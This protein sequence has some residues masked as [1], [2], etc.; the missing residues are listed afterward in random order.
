MLSFNSENTINLAL[1]A[2]QSIPSPNA[3]DAECL[4]LLKLPTK[5]QLKECAAKEKGT[6][7]VKRTDTEMVNTPV[8]NIPSTQSKPR[9]KL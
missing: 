8:T 7:E 4:K 6:L 1:I 2:T 5:A 3:E 9:P